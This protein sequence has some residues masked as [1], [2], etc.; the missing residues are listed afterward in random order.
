MLI[1]NFTSI[2]SAGNC[3]HDDSGEALDNL[4]QFV[5]SG[6]NLPTLP[7][8]AHEKKFNFPIYNP[9]ETVYNI[10]V[11]PISDMTIGYISFIY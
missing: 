9:I 3:E 6:L 2:K 5:E 4:N 1:N 8:S 7:K 11:S 10:Y